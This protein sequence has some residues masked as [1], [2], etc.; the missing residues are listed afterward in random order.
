MARPSSDLYLA[1]IALNNDVMLLA[2]HR[3]E[4]GDES[5]LGHCAVWFRSS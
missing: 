2:A 4:Y 1:S 5:F 3:G